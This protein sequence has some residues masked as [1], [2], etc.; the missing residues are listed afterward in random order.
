MADKLKGGIIGGS[1]D[2]SVPVIL[3][4]TTDNKGLAGLLDASI[5][6]SYWRQGG[7]RVSITT[8]S[9][10][11]ANSAHADGGW[12]EVAS[13]AQPGLY[14]LDVP[15]AAI[16]SAADWVVVSVLPNGATS[17]YLWVQE[18]T[19]TGDPASSLG[20]AKVIVDT[21]S[22][23]AAIKTLSGQLV[24]ATTSVIAYIQSQRAHEDLLA[25]STAL[26][27]YDALIPADLTVAVSS[28]VAYIQS[29]RAHEDLLAASTALTAYDALVPA[30]LAVA[31]SSLTVFIASLRA[32]EDLL[33]ASTALT[34]YDALIPADL[35]VA[36]SSLSVY[37]MSLYAHNDLLAASTALTVYDALVPAD[38]ATAV[39]S[40]VA[41]VSSLRAH[42]DLLAAST[43]LTVYDALVPADLA[44]AVS[45]LS[46]YVM[47][48]YAHNDL[49]AASTALTAYDPPT[50]GEMDTGFAA[51]NDITVAEIAAMTIDTLAAPSGILHLDDTLMW[52][53]AYISGDIGKASTT[54][55]YKDGAGATLWNNDVQPT[56]RTRS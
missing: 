23:A 1:T 8:T 56:A 43:A 38:L 49:L 10:A 12:V 41:Y 51:L 3:R 29:Q 54:F 26:T 2:L 53:A 35:A 42:E 11:A 21:V 31:V 37:V 32:H 6:C 40:I 4:K 16:A 17:G 5:L 9:L 30:D 7:I 15:D 20:F 13:I 28:L 36:V 24:V 22:I 52:V 18:Y 39:T 46:V 50:K 47:S 45:S 44:V 33:A 19:L 55:S 25:A 34:V 14:R 48:L 27:A